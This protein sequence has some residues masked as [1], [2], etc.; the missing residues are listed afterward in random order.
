MLS[1]LVPSIATVIKATIE[2]I[3]NVYF[4][5]IPPLTCS[6][7]AAVNAKCNVAVAC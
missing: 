2:A 6:I 1:P 7:L 5:T 4:I 3:K